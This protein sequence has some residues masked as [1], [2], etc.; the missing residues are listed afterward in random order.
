MDKEEKK[1]VL[2]LIPSNL[3]E[4]AL[5]GMVPPITAETARRLSFL[6][7][8]DLRSARRYLKSLD[9][10][11]DLS[12][13][14]FLLLNEHTREE[15]IPGLLEPMRKG[16]SLGLLSEAGLPAV[17]D[18]GAQLVKAAHQAGF[19]VKP[20]PG[21]SSIYLGL[22]ASGFNGQ[23]FIFHG[24]LPK[25]KNQRIQ[26]IREMEADIARYGRTQIFIETPYRNMSLLESLIFNCREATLLCIASELTTDR[27]SVRV[28]TISAWKEALPEIHK[29]PAVFLL[30]H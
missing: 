21:P 12:K 28:K 29:V 6:V 22:M 2:Y 1:P 15:D 13:I 9:K 7:V 16:H 8:E 14:E 30:Y 17:A 25:E 18:P 24:Y 26:K 27:E 11:I 5:P 10:E 19:D 23:N 4:S 3:S 20:L